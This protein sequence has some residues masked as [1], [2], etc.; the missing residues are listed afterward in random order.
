MGKSKWTKYIFGPVFF[1]NGL[2]ST[3]LGATKIGQIRNRYRVY[4]IS[5]K[6]IGKKRLNSIQL[7]IFADLFF[8]DL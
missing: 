6:N 2:Y 3:H 4:L 1:F 5:K 7:I 8:T